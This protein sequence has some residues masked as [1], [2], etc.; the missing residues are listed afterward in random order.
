MADTDAGEHTGDVL[1]A[2]SWIADVIDA[3]RNE[4][5]QPTAPPSQLG[6]SPESLLHRVVEAEGVWPADGSPV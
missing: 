5:L 4:S 6:V 2:A 3:D 1:S